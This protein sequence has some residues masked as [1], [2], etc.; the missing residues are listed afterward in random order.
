VSAP[1]SFLFVPG[2]RCE[3]IPKAFAAGADAVIVDLEDAVPPQ[4]KD[5]ARQMASAA[6]SLAMPVW[7]RINGAQS[8]WFAADADILDRPGLAGIVL[9]KAE[10]PDDVARLHL[11]SGLPVLPIIESALGLLRLEALARAEGT[12]RLGFGSVDLRADLGV[13]GPER[14]LDGF[15]MNLVLYSRLAALPAP[16]DGPSLGFDDETVVEREAR[17]SAELG[18]GGKFCIHPRQIAPVHRGFAP[19]SA[20]LA[21]ANRVLQADAQAAGRA[22]AVDGQMI[23]RPVVERA[24][25]ILDRQAKPGRSGHQPGSPADQD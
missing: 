17:C 21:W 6:L 12:A 25:R 2:N 7:L 5:A 16:V 19:S 13:P 20:E 10:S 18:F 23:D 24:R 4:E 9:P 11:R 22:V 1:C 15:R 14:L 3:R 8:R